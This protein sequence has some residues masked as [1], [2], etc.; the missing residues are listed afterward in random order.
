MQRLS[1]PTETVLSKTI[2]RNI[3]LIVL[4]FKDSTKRLKPFGRRP[5]L[6]QTDTELALTT[7]GIRS[8]NIFVDSY[9][10]EL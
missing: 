3:I 6:M 7:S 2:T 10:R 1:Y 8:G 5:N 4:S 9:E